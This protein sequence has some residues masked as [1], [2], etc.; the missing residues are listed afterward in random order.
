MRESEATG[1][2]DA[3]AEFDEGALGVSEAPPLIKRAYEK[4]AV[5]ELPEFT[6]A[7]WA[8]LPDRDD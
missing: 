6:A 8:A 5:V 7:D 2:E 1:D 4:P 3:R